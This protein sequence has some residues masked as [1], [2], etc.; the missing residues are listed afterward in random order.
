MNVV[1]RVGNLITQG[2]YTVATPFHP[3]GGAVDVIV[4]QQPD[5]AFR[6]NPWYVRFGKFQGVLKGSEKFVRIAVNGVEADFHMYLDNSGEAYFVKEVVPDDSDNNNNAEFLSVN[7]DFGP[8]ENVRRL[9]HSVSDSAVD[10]LQEERGSGL[11]R[12]ES[13][14]E[15]RFYEFQDDQSS[16]DDSVELSDYDGFEGEN[17]TESLDLD[18][19]VVLVSVD[20]HILT[21]PITAAEKNKF[22]TGENGWAVDYIS[23]VNGGN[24]VNGASCEIASGHE[25]EVCEGD[26]EHHSCEATESLDIRVHIDSEDIAVEDTGLEDLSLS[27][28]A[29]RN[30]EDVG[31]VSGNEDRLSPLSGSVS[32]D[33]GIISVDG[34]CND[35]KE[36][37]DVA[38]SNSFDNHGGNSHDVVSEKSEREEDE[39]FEFGVSESPV[40]SEVPMAKEEEEE[41]GTATTLHTHPNTGSKMTFGFPSI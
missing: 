5:G 4:V 28:E 36:N 27:S 14:G 32:L 15:R 26:G 1:G 17:V 6:S 7:G 40:A 37:G 2:V 29:H 25:L 13:D 18:S 30:A 35:D 38:E 41:E 34:Q 11:E 19:E 39:R 23:K 9:E 21:A 10:E 20:G 24:T 3:F 8:S 12:A 22:G 33:N 31:D 16:L